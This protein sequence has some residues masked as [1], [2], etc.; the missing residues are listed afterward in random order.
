[1]APLVE[2][3]LGLGKIGEGRSLQRLGFERTMEALVLAR[4]GVADGNA[5]F[6][7]PDGA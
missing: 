5:G 2:C 4:P 7:Q 1:M 3:V 6:D